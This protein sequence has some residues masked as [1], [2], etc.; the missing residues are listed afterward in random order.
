MKSRKQCPI[1][2]IWLARVFDTLV[3]WERSGF[4]PVLWLVKG[5][6]SVS[7][8]YMGDPKEYCA[9]EKSNFLAS[10]PNA[11]VLRWHSM[12]TSD[13]R[14]TTSALSA[15]FRILK[16]T[17]Y[18]VKCYSPT[19]VVK[20]PSKSRASMLSASS[21]KLIFCEQATAWTCW[22]TANAVGSSA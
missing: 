14:S 3:G 13:Q 21:L 8:K 11:D 22:T 19:W 5:W 6:G 15:A 9:N 18:R 2:C 1:A 4:S 12:G 16:E 7:F 20:C 17:F 10:K